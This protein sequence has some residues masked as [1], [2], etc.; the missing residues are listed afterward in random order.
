MLRLALGMMICV[1]L[2]AGCSLYRVDSKDAS[3]DFFPP[4]SSPDQVL[5][6][7]KVDKPYDV[8]G[9]VRITTGGMVPREEVVTKMRYEAAILGADAIMDIVSDREPLRVNYTAKAIVFK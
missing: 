8:I 7:E 2:F 1:V 6:L 3:S 4:K 9:I 5:C